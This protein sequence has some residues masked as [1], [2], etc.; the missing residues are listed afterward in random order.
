MLRIIRLSVRALDPVEAA[1]LNNITVNLYAS[2]SLNSLRP[3]WNNKKY[4]YVMDN[5]ILHSL[6]LKLKYL[7]KNCIIQVPASIQNPRTK[8]IFLFTFVDY[9]NNNFYQ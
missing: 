9:Y 3:G 2:S 1:M 8:C 5:I 4:Y 7:Q 6:W